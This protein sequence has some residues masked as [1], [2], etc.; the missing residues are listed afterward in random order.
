MAVR[1]P[2]NVKRMFALFSFANADSDFLQGIMDNIFSGLS[3]QPFS[4]TFEDYG[5]ESTWLVH[6]SGSQ[7]LMGAVFGGLY[8]FAL[9]LSV[10]EGAC[11]KGCCSFFRGFEEGYRFNM[12]FRAF[13]ENFLELFLSVLLNLH[14][15]N[16]SATP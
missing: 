7:L 16:F 11:C 5:F 1:F 4:E 10:L 2:P 6:N 8:P 15:L 3:S 12:P 13:I 9:A 14:F